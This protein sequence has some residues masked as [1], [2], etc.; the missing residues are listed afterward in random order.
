M[1]K[2]TKRGGAS[3]L[4]NVPLIRNVNKKGIYLADDIGYSIREGKKQDLIK[5]YE[6]YL[7]EAT[8]DVKRAREEK[9]R[10]IKDEKNQIEINK[11]T[12]EERKY[13]FNIVKFI[14][15]SL[16]NFIYFL[17]T[18]LIK[19]GP[20]IIDALAKIG[21]GIYNFLS[22]G[23]GVIIKTIVIILIILAIF[24][25]YNAI[26][27][28]KNPSQKV[29]ELVS[30]SK[31]YSSSLFINKTPNFLDNISNTFNS[32]IPDKYKFNF[33]FLKN[34]IN[35][36]VGNDIYEILGEPRNEITTGINDGIYHIKKKDDNDYTY[37]TLKPIAIKIPKSIFKSITDNDF[38]KLPEKL[39]KEYDDNDDDYI[40][41]VIINNSNNS[42]SYEYDIENI[43]EGENGQ[44]LKD[45]NPNIILPFKKTDIQNVFKFNKD[46]A[47]IFNNDDKSP[48]LTLDKMFNYKNG[49]YIYPF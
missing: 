41:P 8:E 13:R 17:V 35:T 40:I 23:Q 27:E 28:G 9:E 42:Q 1:V 5:K 14:V 22:M 24:F 15:Y 19:L 44:I 3:I 45:K 38:S 47:I 49:K 16:G 10:N 31:N 2:I 37:T 20:L 21:T 33:N 11:G 29:N 34:R 26:F 25:G 18:S 12:L 46:K 6:G 43:Q 32:F 48:S 4:E 36:L 30:N 7:N 39:Q